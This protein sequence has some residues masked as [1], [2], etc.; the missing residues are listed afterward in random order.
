MKFNLETAK[1]KISNNL[2]N[3]MSKQTSDLV[4]KANS[5]CQKYRGSRNGSNFG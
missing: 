5:V 2:F 1:T 3:L 4:S